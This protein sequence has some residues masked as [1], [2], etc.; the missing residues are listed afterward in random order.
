M[1]EE[2]KAV[3]KVEP[4]ML[5]IIKSLIETREVSAREANKFIQ[6]TQQAQGQ[7]TEYLRQCAGTLGLHPDEY[8]FV[9]DKLGFVHKSQ[10]AQTTQ[11]EVAPSPTNGKRDLKLVPKPTQPMPVGQ[12]ESPESPLPV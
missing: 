6:Q 2:T 7:I 5:A 4:Y 9:D 10:M 3:V 12:V 8:V 11:V 1:T